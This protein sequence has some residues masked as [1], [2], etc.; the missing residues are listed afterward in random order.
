[1]VRSS[2]SKSKLNKLVLA[3]IPKKNKNTKNT[4]A[5]SQGSLLKQ[6]NGVNARGR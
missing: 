1:M 4:A 6:V 3:A 2:I 5:I